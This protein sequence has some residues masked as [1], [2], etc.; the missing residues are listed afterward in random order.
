MTGSIRSVSQAFAILRLLADEDA[1]TLTDIGKLIG[2][3]PSSSFNLLKT[4]EA[5]GVIERELRTKRYRLALPWKNV[6]ALHDS[7]AARLVARSLPLLGRFAQANE[8]A[9]GLWKIVSRDRLQLAARGE[10]KAGMRLTLADGQRQ[11]LGAGAAGRAIAAAQDI[12]EAE[13]ARRF[14]SVRWQSKLTF[15][16]YARQVYEARANGFAVDDGYAHRGVLTVATALAD[17]APGFCLTA[18]FFAGPRT[19][20]ELESLAAAISKLGEEIIFCLA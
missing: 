17:V 11:P 4:L 10:C 1:L 12:D 3:S 19:E 18:S 13:L 14:G 5:E 2:T 7:A 15:E 20:R 9:I 8:A 16:T 6:D